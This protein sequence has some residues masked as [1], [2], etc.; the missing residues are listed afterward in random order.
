MRYRNGLELA[1]VVIATMACVLAIGYATGWNPT[2]GW[3]LTGLA[4]VAFAGA[5]QRRRNRERDARRAR[6]LDPD[7]P[8]GDGRGP[9]GV[10]RQDRDRDL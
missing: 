5:S 8:R 2:L 3:I 1:A 4:L 10:L 7:G 6:G 9:D